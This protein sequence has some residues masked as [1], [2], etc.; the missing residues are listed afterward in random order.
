MLDWRAQNEQLL[1]AVADASG[2][3]ICTGNT[4]LLPMAHKMETL[5]PMRFLEGKS[6]DGLP[7]NCLYAGQLDLAEFGAQV[8]VNLMRHR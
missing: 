2:P 7:L 1:A 5:L 8:S 6:V 4:S 3:G